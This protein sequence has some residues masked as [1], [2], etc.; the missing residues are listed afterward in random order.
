MGQH[1]CRCNDRENDS[2]SD[3]TVGEFRRQFNYRGVADVVAGDLEYCLQRPPRIVAF[4]DAVDGGNSLLIFLRG[5]SSSSSGSGNSSNISMHNYSNAKKQLPTTSEEQAGGENAVSRSVIGWWLPS[6]GGGARAPLLVR[7]NESSLCSPGC[8]SEGWKAG[9]VSAALGDDTCDIMCDVLAC[10][11]D[12]GDC[13][14]SYSQREST[15]IGIRDSRLQMER[16]KLWLNAG[17]TD[18]W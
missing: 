16:D 14:L 3:T 7:G 4:S 9:H 11:Y 8:T 2:A 5:S 12:K 17:T 1:T 10:N 6:P 15:Y 13:T 18:E